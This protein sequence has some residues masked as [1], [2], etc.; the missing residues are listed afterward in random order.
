MKR[1]KNNCIVCMYT[2]GVVVVVVVVRRPQRKENKIGNKKK[3]LP[4][5][6][7]RLFLFFPFFVVSALS[8]SS[9]SFSSCYNFAL[10]L[11]FSW[12]SS[13]FSDDI[14]SKKT[15]S[16]SC[17]RCFFSFVGGGGAGARGFGT[18]EE[19]DEEK[20]GRGFN[21]FQLLCRDAVS[22]Q[23]AIVF[24][25]PNWGC[26]LLPKSGEGNARFS[27]HYKLGKVIFG[28]KFWGLD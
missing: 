4:P 27:C 11:Q 18:G 3:V 13:D 20:G 7:S 10:L 15:S 9:S 14:F 23:M 19:D 16:N 1:G 12:Y 6:R 21:N 24:Q 2:L 25:V 26:Q 28:R 8:S 22:G 5:F 17:S